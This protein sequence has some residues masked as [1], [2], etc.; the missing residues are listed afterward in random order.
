MGQESDDM[1]KNEYQLVTERLV[2]HP[3][4]EWEA[5]Q[6]RI[7]PVATG[8]KRYLPLL[9][10]GDEQESMIADTWIVVKCSSCGTGRISL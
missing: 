7:L 3:W 6:V 10:I 2:L 1:E 4:R 5:D 8:K 9:L